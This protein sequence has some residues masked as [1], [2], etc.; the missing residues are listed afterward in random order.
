MLYFAYIFS[1]RGLLDRREEARA[2]I[3]VLFVF[4][5]IFWAA[6]EQAPTSLNLFARDFTNRTIGSAS[7]FRPTWFQVDELGVHHHLRAGVR[8][9]SGWRMAKRGWELS[10]P[11]KFALGLVLRRYRLP[12]HDPAVER[13]RR[14]PRRARRSRRWWLTISYIFQTLGELSLSPVGLSSMTKLSPR[15]F[16]GQMMGVWFLATSL[17][18]L[19]AGL[20]G[21]NVDPE[22]LE[23]TPPLFDRTTIALHAAAV[24]LALLMIPIRRMM[25]KAEA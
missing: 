3:L 6:F 7:W 11:A 17:G 25:R 22:K 15:K 13:P 9:A 23:Q 8:V 5:A 14:E 4:S 2:V 24:V 18:N 21:G 12:H 1:S 20:V 16:V 19:I 10:S